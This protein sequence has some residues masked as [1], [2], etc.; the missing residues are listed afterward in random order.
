MAAAWPGAAVTSR[1]ARLQLAPGAA[2]TAPAPRLRLLTTSSS[3]GAALLGWQRLPL[4]SQIRPPLLAARAGGLAQ[5]QRLLTAS[6]SVGAALLG[7]Q[8]LPLAHPW[9]C[10]IH[11]L[12]PTSPAA[13][14]PS[15]RR[16]P[17]PSSLLQ[18]PRIAPSS[19]L[20]AILSSMLL[21]NFVQT[22]IP[23]LFLI[24]F[25]LQRQFRGTRGAEASNFCTPS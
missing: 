25:D 18:D 20:L 12:H 6:S 24:F 9:I 3:A 23:F 14:R 10:V 1:A 16:R 13:P 8:R 19:P 22:L 15:R 4:A 7:W 17:L 5:A 11:L 2:S 21:I